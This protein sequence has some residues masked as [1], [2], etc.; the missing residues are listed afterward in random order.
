MLDN[1][2]NRF[3]D[4]FARLRRRGAL[5]ESDV[6]EA[7]REVRVALLEADVALPVV[8]DFIARIRDRAVGT[9]VL[10]SITPAQ[11]VIKIVHDGLVDMLGAESAG[12]DLTA[13]APVVVMLAGLQGSGKT[14]TAAKLAKRLTTRE[15]R[16]VL[17]ASLDVRRPAAQEQLRI[18]GESTNVA[19]L[20]II[21]GQDAVTIAQRAL[22]EARKGGFD[23][24]I[25]DTAGRLAIDEDM[26]A[27]AVA[28]RDAAKPHE[29]LLVADA[30]TGQDAVRTAETF[31]AR[32][33]LSGI[34]LT[35]M[36][37][38]ARGGAALSMRAVTGCPIKLI[39]T[40]EK[41]DA[42]DSFHPQRMAGRILDM[43][44]VVSLVEKAVETIDAGEAETLAKRMQAGI[45]TLED[46][47][48]QLR[49]LTRMGGMGG[50]L[51]LLPGMRGARQQLAELD[52]EGKLVRRQLAI[53]GSMTRKERRKPEILNASRRRRI[54]AGS[55]ANVH[56]VNVLIKQFS[57]MQDMMKRM[58]KMGGKDLSGLASGNFPPGGMEKLL[59]RMKT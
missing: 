20:A 1:L 22:D 55:G 54:A 51:K 37:G 52:P 11:Q 4:I 27:E 39:G 47:G 32:L 13:P 19:T 35:R 10:Q 42:L 21:P 46:F 25:L 44:D 9:D 15:A 3:S 14:T 23:V 58:R 17:M 59:G 26:M 34:I 6:G 18:L 56:D 49:Q 40:G 50:L 30:M 28:V 12:I 24:L 45:F 38:D 36:D 41:I 16:K 31:N 53:I 57:Q 48:T 5:T 2:T 8:K 33:G 43:G 7:L 29:I